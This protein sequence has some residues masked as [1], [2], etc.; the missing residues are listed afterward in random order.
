MTEA[1]FPQ[2]LTC[3]GLFA[4]A[5]TVPYRN[6]LA[7]QSNDGRFTRDKKWGL[8]RPF[9]RRNGVGKADS[10]HKSPASL[11]LNDPAGN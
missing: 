2:A 9:E 5:V 1:L 4:I 6:D 7:R 8:H 11:I 10:R 3:A